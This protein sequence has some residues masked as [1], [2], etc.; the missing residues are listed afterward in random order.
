MVQFLESVK[1]VFSKDECFKCAS[2]EKII[3]VQM[4]FVFVFIYNIYQSISRIEKAAEI[5]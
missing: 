4:A 5:F 3:A 2:G 1:E